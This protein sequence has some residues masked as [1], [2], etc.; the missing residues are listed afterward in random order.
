MKKFA[1]IK[2]LF[3]YSVCLTGLFFTIY[4]FNKLNNAFLGILL[5]T[6]LVGSIVAITI[7]YLKK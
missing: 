5:I 6:V 2:L 1:L 4:D 7:N 3:I